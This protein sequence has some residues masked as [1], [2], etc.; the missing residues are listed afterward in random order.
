MAEKGEIMFC[1]K[2]G[3]KLKEGARFCGSC[4]NQI[5]Q[6]ENPVQQN[7]P[8]L[9]IVNPTQAVK[10]TESTQIIKQGELCYT[11]GIIKKEKGTLTLYTDR[12]EWK[13]E[14]GNSVVIKI[15]EVYTVD[16]NAILDKFTIKLVNAQNHVFIK[17]LTAGR[18]AQG[19]AFGGIVSAVTLKQEFEGWQSAI[20][21]LRR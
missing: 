12:L 19:L 15:C 11:G 10:N 7:Q 2:C 9:S 5:S 21:N 13:G 16:I 6:P 8:A 17:P 4:G 20:Y 14:K 1:S 18:L 3:G